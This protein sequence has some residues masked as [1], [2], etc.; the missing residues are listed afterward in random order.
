M[1]VDPML[2]GLVEGFAA[3][4][5]DISQRVTLDLLELEREGAAPDALRKAYDRLGRQLH[6]L[7]GSAASLGL[8][9]VAD[10]AHRMEDAVAP[11]REGAQAMPR[12]LV[13]ALLW[14][15][16]ETRDR[17]PT[18]MDEVRNVLYFFEATLFRLLPTVYRE[19]E[20]ALADTYPGEE[21]TV[22]SV[23]RYGSWVGGDRDG[24]PNVTVEITEE[25]IRAQKES[26]LRHYNVVVDELYNQL[27]PATTRVAVSPALIA[28]GIVWACTIGL[29]GGLFPAVRAARLPVATALRAI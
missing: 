25:A 23:L 18:V 14:Q 22:G 7:K 12:T 19:L 21:F 13:D 28:T 9:D 29:I 26:I 1:G 24:N 11:L 8:E 15:S 5:S 27:S 16:D 10:V 20:R 3:E 4:A 6:T 17:R 2:R